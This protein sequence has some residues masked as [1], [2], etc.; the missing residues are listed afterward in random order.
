MDLSPK[1]SAVIL[2]LLLLGSTGMECHSQ[3]HRF[4]GPCVRDANC[5]TVCLTEGFTGGKCEGFRSRCFC[6]KSC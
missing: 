5:A 4:K 3:S 2:L 1:L 6:I